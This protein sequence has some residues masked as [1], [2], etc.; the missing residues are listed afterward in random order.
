M[1]KIPH[2]ASNLCM[3]IRW[4][5]I[6]GLAVA[7]SR[8]ADAS[9]AGTS[10]AQFLKLGIGPRAIAMGEAQVA[11]ADDVYATY[12]NP[13]GLARLPTKEAGFVQNQYLQS[14][15]QLFAAFAYPTDKL[16]TFAGSFSY[17]NYGRFQGYDAGGSPIG[18]IGANDLD[19]AA[20]YATSLFYDRSLGSSLSFG[21][22]GKW[23]QEKLDTVS[24]KA[25]AMDGGVLFKPGLRWGGI[26]EGWKAGATIRNLGTELKYDTESFPLPRSLDAGI[27]YTGN[28]MREGVT[29]ALDVHQPND[30][31]RSFGTGVEVWTLQTFVLRA[32]YTSRG[33]IGNG[34]R[35]GAGIRFKT[36]QVDYAYA[37][38]KDLGGTN[39]IGLT[40]RFKQVSADPVFLSQKHYDK[41]MELFRRRR[42][43]EALVEFNKS[44]ELDPQHPDSLKM[45]KQT[46]E[47]IKILTPE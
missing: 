38:A 36:V 46:Y 37:S 31:S 6:L 33:D 10:S 8:V 41:G 19:V 24:A 21:V 26:L 2:F 32:G 29:W 15:S 7:V 40:V 16:G 4:M 30:G 20:S 12:W 34:L 42:F 22:T 14:I 39:Y 5:C 47:Q 27:S 1:N 9:D 3:N 13:A 43:T 17:L 23:I 44:L 45:M 35:V 11:V 28:I 25:Y 18:S